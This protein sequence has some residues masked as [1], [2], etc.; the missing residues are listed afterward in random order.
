ML[1]PSSTAGRWAGGF[2]LLAVAL[3]AGFAVLVASGERGG[4]TFFSNPSLAA[5]MLGA[6]AAVVAAGCAGAVALRRGDRSLPVIVSL[7][8]AILVVLWWT[9]ELAFPH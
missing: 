3:L 5:T 1:V 7:V 4:D 9:A 6:T 2:L 8:V